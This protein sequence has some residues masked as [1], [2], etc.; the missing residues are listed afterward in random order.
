VYLTYPFVL[1]WSLLEAMACGCAI[2][3]SDTAPL[4]EAIVDQD[5]GILVDFFSP[6]QLADSVIKLLEDAPL[7]KR[8]GASAR[9]FAVANYDLNAV[10]LPRMLGLIERVATKADTKQI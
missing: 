9:A 3:A 1:S 2:V 4:R 8:L 5:T 7:R 6:S 10:C